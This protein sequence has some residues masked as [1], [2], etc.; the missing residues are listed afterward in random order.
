M[1][2]CAMA[3]FGSAPAFLISRP[4]PGCQLL[5][6]VQ[7]KQMTLEVDDDRHPDGRCR[8]AAS[9]VGEGW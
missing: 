5:Q 2:D 4:D 9:R 7:L 6:L 1:V 8:Q 3:A